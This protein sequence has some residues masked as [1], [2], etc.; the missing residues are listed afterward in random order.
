VGTSLPEIALSCLLGCRPHTT[1]IIA[2]SSDYNADAARINCDK[3]TSSFKSQVRLAD[4]E[5]P[6]GGQDTN[7]LS[8]MDYALRNRSILG[9]A[10]ALLNLGL[11]LLDNDNHKEQ[12]DKYLYE[13]WDLLES[14]NSDQLQN[15]RAH[16]LMQ[17]LAR[18]AVFKDRPDLTSRLAG[19]LRLPDACHIVCLFFQLVSLSL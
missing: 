15:D 11:G 14:M 6:Q 4:Y 10:E 13:S 12:A 7:R 1:E 17:R 19:L 2:S 8:M 5:A 16:T 3:K 18:C 9:Q